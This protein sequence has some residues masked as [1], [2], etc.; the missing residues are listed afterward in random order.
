MLPLYSGVGLWRRVGLPQVAMF[1]SPDDWLQTA[2]GRRPPG[3]HDGVDGLY[4]GHS[5]SSATEQMLTVGITLH[6][7]HTDECVDVHVFGRLRP[8]RSV[9]AVCCDLPLCCQYSRQGSAVILQTFCLF[10]LQRSW[11]VLFHTAWKTHWTYDN[12]TPLCPRPSRCPSFSDLCFGLWSR[13]SFTSGIIYLFC[14]SQC[15]YVRYVMYTSIVCWSVLSQV[16]V[17][18]F[19]VVYKLSK[20]VLQAADRLRRMCCLKTS[21]SPV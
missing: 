14:R 8:A 15:R 5:G 1:D 18:K 17:H 2:F 4:I 19:F 16:S 6:R 12:S 13:C 10:E 20:L 7:V 11:T 21:P 9:S 3:R